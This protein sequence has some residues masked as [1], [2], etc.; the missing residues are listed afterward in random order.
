MVSKRD[1]RFY[2]SV[3]SENVKK[4]STMS[5]PEIIISASDDVSQAEVDMAKEYVKNQVAKRK[6]YQ[7]ESD[8]VQKEV[9]RFALVN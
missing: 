9:G 1:I 7:N 3:V 2:F 8:K 4:D 5:I 6:K